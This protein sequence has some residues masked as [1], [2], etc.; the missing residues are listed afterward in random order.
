MGFIFKGQGQEMK[1][2]VNKVVIEEPGEWISE[3]GGWKCSCCGKKTTF[4]A[5]IYGDYC[6]RCGHP[7]NK[8]VLRDRLRAV[9]ESLG[10]GGN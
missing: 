9:Y 8:Q 6:P 1:G 7:M 10:R 2:A 3:K 5:L 4:D